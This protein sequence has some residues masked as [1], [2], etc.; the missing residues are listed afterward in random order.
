MAR[1]S[2]SRAGG[3]GD[4]ALRRR[5][6]F[7][8]VPPDPGLLATVRLGDAAVDLPAVLGAINDRL[9]FLLGPGSA[10]ITGTDL[11]VDGGLTAAMD[12]PA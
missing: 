9:E 3:T 8:E 5:F 7:E 4:T 6:H 11:L 10:Y 1:R 2:S 12:Y